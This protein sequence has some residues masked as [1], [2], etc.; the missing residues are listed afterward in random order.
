MHYERKGLYNNLLVVALCVAAV[1]G[2]SRSLAAGD[3]PAPRL[4]LTPL[5]GVGAAEEAASVEATLGQLHGNTMRTADPRTK[6]RASLD[7]ALFALTHGTEPALTWQGLL[8]V[9]DTREAARGLASLEIA[10]EALAWVEKTRQDKAL[11]DPEMR[12]MQCEGQ[13]LSALAAM[14]SVLLE[15]VQQAE[16][17]RVARQA[18]AAGESLPETAR[19]AWDL[20]IAACLDRA[21]RSQDAELRLQ[22]L[23]RRQKGSAAHLPAEVFSDRILAR[24][25]S[26]AA[27]VALVDEHLQ[28]AGWPQQ[29]TSAADSQK[30]GT[31]EDAA[32][33]QPGGTGGTAAQVTFCTL[34][35]TKANLLADWAG[36]LDSASGEPYGRQTAEVLRKESAKCMAQAR[37]SGPYVVRLLPVLEPLGESAAYDKGPA[38]VPTLMPTS[39]SR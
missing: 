29:A 36:Q 32:A 24:A 8:G 30:A 5:E 25:G 20:L 21:G 19:P 38:S 28:A 17:L 15:K 37:E 9:R 16:A 35:L 22:G 2:V 6:A 4:L 7:L 1:C 31:G 34:L 11:N 27:A 23:L 10:R 3:A 33:S 18:E 39:L 13:R 26:Y 14:E 12:S